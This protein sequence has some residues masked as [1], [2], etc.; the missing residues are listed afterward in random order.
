MGSDGPYLP[1]KI[2]SKTE[3]VSPDLHP[4]YPGS[5]KMYRMKEE[6]IEGVQALIKLPVG[7][8]CFQILLHVLTGLNQVFCVVTPYVA[9]IQL[10]LDNGGAVA[11]VARK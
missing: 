2:F 8:Y 11:S 6:L 4:V 10:I 3:K 7:N 9:G 5:G 1:V